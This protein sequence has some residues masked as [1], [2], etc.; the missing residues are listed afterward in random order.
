MCRVGQADS[1]SMFDRIEAE[2]S[3]LFEMVLQ[4]ACYV[5]KPAKT[6]PIKSRAIRRLPSSILTY[7]G[8]GV[9]K[10]WV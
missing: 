10:H 1:V 5:A 4:R 2:Y 8:G 7:K 3:M 6:S 9:K